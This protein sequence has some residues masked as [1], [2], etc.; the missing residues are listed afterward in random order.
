LDEVEDFLRRN[1]LVQAHLVDVRAQRAL[2]LE[3]AARS[4]IRH[5]SPQVIVFQRGVPT[6]NASHDDI[7]A[8]EIERHLPD[9]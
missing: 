4:G 3:I 1:P 9:R 6:W 8:H 2:S 5:E 7:S